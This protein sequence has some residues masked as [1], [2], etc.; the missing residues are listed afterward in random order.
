MKV[1]SVRAVGTLAVCG[2]IEPVPPLLLKVTVW[3][4]SAVHWAYRV[5]SAVKE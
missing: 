5:T 1:L 2:L 4:G 3:F